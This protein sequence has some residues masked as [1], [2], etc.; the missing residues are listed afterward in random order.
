MWSS[1]V[2]WTR[3][4]PLPNR[5]WLASLLSCFL[6]LA[7]GF[8]GPA[9]GAGPTP[10]PAA[11]P[12]AGSA[13]E[14]PGGRVSAAD[15]IPSDLTVLQFSPRLVL[16]TFTPRPGLSFPSPAATL[17]PSP[18][19]VPRLVSDGLK[20]DTSAG[21][22]A[23]FRA[24]LLD[25]GGPRLLGAEVVSD[26][27]ARFP[28]EHP[29]CVEEGWAPAFSLDRTC[30]SVHVGGRLLPPGLL[31]ENPASAAPSAG[32]T[33]A[34]SSGNLLVHFSRM[35]FEQL[36]GCWYYD[37]ER[38]IWAWSLSDGQ[39]GFDRVVQSACDGELQ[40]QLLLT[41]LPTAVAVVELMERIRVRYPLDCAAAAWSQFPSLV[42]HP[43]CFYEGPTG[44]FEDGSL[45]INWLPGYPATDGSV[46]WYWD[47]G[48]GSWLYFYDPR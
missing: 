14:A 28:V 24:Q 26:L 27:A 38:Q 13:P 15:A 37:A 47:P 9:A 42:S 12:A 33:A 25:Y 7:C 22:E 30:L 44:R 39:E 46:C 19:P 17:A 35:P 29:G 40:R 1:S 6:V 16:P 36:A 20:V 10:G 43:G 18:T 41:H 31:M 3:W 21:C 4:P 32:P 48:D 23:R 5:V 8:Q 11:G 2:A 34:D 45:L